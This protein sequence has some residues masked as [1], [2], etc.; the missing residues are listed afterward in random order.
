MHDLSTGFLINLD[1]LQIPSVGKTLI[2][3]VYDASL[4]TCLQTMQKLHK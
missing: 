1:P 2:T 3:Q 4:V